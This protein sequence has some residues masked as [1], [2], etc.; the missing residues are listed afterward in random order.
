MDSLKQE[1]ERLALKV[2]KHSEVTNGLE[3]KLE[4][5][6]EELNGYQVNNELLRETCT[7]LEEQ[8][9]DYERLTSDH[10]FRENTLIQEKMKLQKDLEATEGR[11]R[12]ATAAQNEEKTMRLVAERAIQRLESETSDIEEERNSLASQRDQYKKMAQQLSKQ[13]AELTAKCGELEC[14]L[15]EL[16]RALENAKGEARVV[17]EESSQHLTK[18]HELRE[19]N[20]AL[21][22]DLQDSV[23][24]GQQ[25]RERVFELEAVL[26]EMRQF[27]NEREM[28][29]GST[30]QQQT[31]L[32]GNY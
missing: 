11:L 2:S 22:E 29:A 4:K 15:A 24:Q 6:Q 30:Q 5:L 18:M 25:L 21:M 13:V 7:V 19:E 8:L 27:Y 9:T 31:K 10:E 28:K 12:E 17:K 1:N 32:I 23:D 3:A 14:D 26:E 20:S 16:Q